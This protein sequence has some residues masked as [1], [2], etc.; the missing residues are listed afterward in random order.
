MSV[1][2][3]LWRR[4][5]DVIFIEFLQYWVWPTVTMLIF[6]IDAIFR[7]FKRFFARVKL[8][9][10]E[11]PTSNAIV[12][13]FRVNQHL[14]LYPGDFILLQCENISTLE[15]HPFTIIDSVV[16]PKRT[17]FSLYITTRGDWTRELYEK[18]FKLLIQIEK[19]K[20]KRR[21]KRNRR[22]YSTLRKLSFIADG[23]FHSPME[24]IVGCERVILIAEGIG[25][26]PF[27]AIFNFI[28]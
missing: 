23:P 22:K 21:S 9:S 25:I 14:S 18:I 17:I 12:L 28:L 10:M 3:I 6:L 13:T 15:W 24:S 2:E 20:R 1:D 5:I 11:L 16:E 27:I 8:V 4:R 19:M 7:Y 26:A